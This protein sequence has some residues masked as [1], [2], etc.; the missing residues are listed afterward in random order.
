MDPTNFIQ[1][2]LNYAGKLYSILCKAVLVRDIL[3]S[4][5]INNIKIKIKKI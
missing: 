1:D 2:V 3:I 4:L 5:I